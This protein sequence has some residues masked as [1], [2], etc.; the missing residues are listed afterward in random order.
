[1]Q[2]ISTQY[3]GPTDHRGSR[4]RAKASYAK[5]TVWYDWDYRLS[6]E[7]NHKEAARQ[8]IV[9]LEWDQLLGDWVMGG[10]EKGYIFVSTDSSFKL[11]FKQA[12]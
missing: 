2:T 3:Y 9:K 11:S 5:T 4:V 1:M 8:L 10:T 7:D 6:P 12:A